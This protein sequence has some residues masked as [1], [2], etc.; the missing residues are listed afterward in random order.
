M[1]WEAVKDIYRCVLMHNFK[2]KYLDDDMYKLNY[3]SNG[4][5]WEAEYKNR[6]RHGKTIW[7]SASGQILYEENYK[8]GKIIKK[9]NVVI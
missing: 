8:N 2:I 4:I 1:N 5:T 6:V 3:L 7:R 9:T